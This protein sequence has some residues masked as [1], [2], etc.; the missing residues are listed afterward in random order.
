MVGMKRSL[1]SLAFCAVL[2]AVAPTHA[3][4]ANATFLGPIVPEEC[5]CEDQIVQGTGEPIDT[6][7]DYGCVLQVVQNV[8]NFGITLSTILFTIYLVITGLSFITSGDSSEARSKAKTRF[9]N[10]FIGL[11]VL[12]L[13]WLIVDYVMKTIYDENSIFGP[14]NAIL[15]PQADGSDRCIVAKEPNAVFTGT[16]GVPVG[17][18]SGGI[19]TSADAEAAAGREQSARKLLSNAGVNIWHAACASPSSRNCTSVGGTRAATLQQVIIVRN[20][21]CGSNTSCRIV[22]TGGSEGGHAAG[23]FSHGNGYK[24]DID[25]TGGVNRVLG[26]LTRTGTRG[27]D[28]GGPIFKDSCGNEYVHE[29]NHWDITVQ[30]ACQ[31]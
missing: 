2:L 10:V 12:L 9:T 7:P 28:F 1:L 24:V 18:T 20:A 13:A 30:T 21:V 8:I 19:G 4:A 23:T 25:D 22:V 5:T 15:A 31:L 3:Q 14:W 26:A 27:G 16:V 11:A 17:G 6:A 29:S